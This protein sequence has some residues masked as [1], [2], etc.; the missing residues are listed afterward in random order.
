MS[1]TFRPE[2]ERKKISK[3]SGCFDELANRNWHICPLIFA[4]K[5]D[6]GGWSADIG[7][8]IQPR[9]SWTTS[10]GL[11]LLIR[12]VRV[13]GLCERPIPFSLSWV[14]PCCFVLLCVSVSWGGDRSLFLQLYCI[15]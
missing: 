13:M 12:E 7:P 4:R 3:T 6:R 15:I 10:L 14:A 9:S 1:L 11:R 5:F 2:E 8:R